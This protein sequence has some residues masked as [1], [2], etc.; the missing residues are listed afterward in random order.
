MLKLLAA[1]YGGLLLAAGILALTRRLRWLVMAV[2]IVAVGWFLTI[3]LTVPL[4]FWN[5]PQWG[6][7]TADLLVLIA[8]AVLTARYRTPWLFTVTGLQLAT[9]TLHIAYALAPSLSGFAYAGAQQILGWAVLWTLLVAGAF[10]K[11]SPTRN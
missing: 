3:G 9:V 6:I 8:F 2:L 10:A 7:F 4:H 11:L 1:A 5:G